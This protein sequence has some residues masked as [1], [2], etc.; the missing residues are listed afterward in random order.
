[1]KLSRII[2]LILFLILVLIATGVAGCATPE[3]QR[4]MSY[5]QAMSKAC[6]EAGGVWYRG[7]METDYE[8]VDRQ[9]LVD[10]IDR[11]RGMSW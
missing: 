6:R 8:C 7:P 2:F 10:A 11:R 4:A 3:T 5:E 9:S 1:M